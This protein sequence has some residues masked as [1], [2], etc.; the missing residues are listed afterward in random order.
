M[1]LKRPRYL[2]IGRARSTAAPVKLLL[3]PHRH[4]N[5]MKAPTADSERIHTSQAG[6]VCLLKQEISLLL[7]NI[8]LNLIRMRSSWPWHVPCLMPTV[9]LRLYLHGEHSHTR[10]T[11][12]LRP[13][14]RPCHQRSQFCFE[15]AATCH[16]G[17]MHTGCRSCIRSC[18][19]QQLLGEWLRSL[20][21]L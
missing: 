19:Q 20:Y 15:T 10:Q 9:S 21:P 7:S 4:V 11:H 18:C 3:E 14:R 2:S 5:Y 12:D 6:E 17:A 16:N 1:Y 13:R 8:F